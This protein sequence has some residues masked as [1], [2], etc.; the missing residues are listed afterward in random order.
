MKKVVVCNIPLK[1][2]VDAVQ[3][4]NN[5]NKDLN[6]EKEVIFPINALLS[7]TSN[8]EDEIKIV[9][10]AKET[11]DK[12][13]D[14]NIALFKSEL[15]SFGV[16]AKVEYKLIVTPFVEDKKINDYLLENIV[17]SVDENSEIYCDVTYG[18][19]SLPIILFT[20]LRFLEKNCGCDIKN[21]VY[22]K[23][24]FSKDGLKNPEICDLMSLYYLN[25]INEKMSFKSS[26]QA[27]E[28]LHLL[29]DI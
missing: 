19:K 1:G 20:A 2:K 11:Q 24:D 29:L 18:P 3:Y 6:V 28:S 15:E 8:E 22:G 23:V 9:L 10:L 21:I 13:V 7:N 4:P 25:S 17:N 26:K 27:K 14:N 5:D 16:K 12:F